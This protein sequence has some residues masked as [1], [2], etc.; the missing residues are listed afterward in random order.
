MKSLPVIALF[1]AACASPSSARLPGPRTVTSSST[2]ARASTQQVRS[3]ITAEGECV[4]VELIEN[5]ASKGPICVAEAQARGLTVVDL[6]ESWTPT[7]FQPTRDGIV[8][9]FRARYLELAAEHPERD[10]EPIDALAEL[11]GIVPALSIV[12][13]RL[14][15]DS[16]HACLAAVD[17]TPLRSLERTFSQDD[18]DAVR[19]QNNGRAWLASQLDKERVKRKLE[20]IAALETDRTWHERY[21]RWRKLDE[22]HRALVAAQQKLRCEGWLVDK[23][24]DGSF[25]WRTGD[26]M[27]SFQRRNFLMPT[28]RLDKDTREAM[29]QGSY[30][31]DFRLAL[32]VLRERVTE[33]SGLLEDGTAGEG[34]R[35][36]LQRLLDPPAMRAARGHHP[37]PNAAPD[38]VGA[39]T[40]AA[41]LQLG[42]TSP[43]AVREFLERYPAGTKVAI[44]LPPVPAYHTA[45]MQLS[46]EID[47]GDVYYDERPPL[48]R[49]AVKHR[50]TLVVY[51]TDGAIKRPLVRWPTTIG[52]WADQRL[53]GG[54]V[55]QK[56]KESDV[57]PRVW[58]N[59][60][61]GPTW[62]PPKTTPDKD[63]VRNLYDRGRFALKDDIF[64][65]GPRSAYGMVLIEH[66]EQVKLRDGSIRLD[67]NGIGTHGSA[68]VTSIVNGTSHGCH[69]LYN[70]LAT[71]LGNFLLQHRTYAVKGEQKVTYRRLIWHNNQSFKAEI[72]TRGFQY[73]LT[74]P[75]PVNVTKGNILS[76]RKRP[77]RNSAP[78]RP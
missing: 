54:G 7:I 53:P 60:T 40:E 76:D 20:S 3:T 11:Y 28:E 23:D 39:A 75:V 31:L 64:G 22:T 55:V 6:G 18:K 78:A 33:A 44:A 13:A 66:F 26:A 51:A 70:Q 49:R 46:V 5:G 16:R 2:T 21:V 38:L 9:E 71:R 63:L 41:A 24:V 32:R 17:A 29:Q 14:A 50:P 61:A 12:R 68:S 37:M 69:R 27:E 36:I 62:L 45:H 73:E 34:P 57:G 48:V 43:S 72:D 35:P 15:D 67:D 8:P 74:P 10:A 59:L 47:R 65:P 56:W 4:S 77:P 1:L 25:T 30:E 52:G 19:A 42:W 58:Q